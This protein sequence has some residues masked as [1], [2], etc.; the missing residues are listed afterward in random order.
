MEGIPA[1]YLG[2]MVPKDK[3][4]AFIYASD[5]ATKLV[6][7]WDEFERHMETGLWFASIDDI[8]PI[9][10][11]VPLEDFKKGKSQKERK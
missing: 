2:R 6:N 3:F 7:S 4:R 11:D 5:G 1:L 10:Q 9:A 8:K